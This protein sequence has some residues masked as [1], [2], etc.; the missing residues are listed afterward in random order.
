MHQISWLTYLRLITA[1]AKDT[2]LMLAVKEEHVKIAKYLINQG[3]LVNLSNSSGFTPLHYAA[4]K[5]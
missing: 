2:P 1:A 3:A 4:I 5:G